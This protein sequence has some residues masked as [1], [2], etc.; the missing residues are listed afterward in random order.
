[1]ESNPTIPPYRS[2]SQALPPHRDVVAEEFWRQERKLNAEKKK[3]CKLKKRYADQK[4]RRKQAERALAKERS[5]AALRE[6]EILQTK[7]DDWAFYHG[8]EEGN[9]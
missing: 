6:K 5:D 8:R 9:R 1:M 7:L 4:S 2:K 3:R